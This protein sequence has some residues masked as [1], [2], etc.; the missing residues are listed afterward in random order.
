MDETVESTLTAR[1]REA[2]GDDRRLACW[3]STTGEEIDWD[4]L[5]FRDDVREA[6]GDTDEA[7][8]NA[9]R[10]IDDTSLDRPG[11]SHAERIHAAGDLRCTTRVFEAAVAVHVG[12]GDHGRIVSD[13]QAAE[14][15][16]YGFVTAAHERLERADRDAQP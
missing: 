14:V 11:D 15:D 3:Y 2:F 7:R 9:A 1:C 8:T 10:V 16:Q 13:D 12:A 5:D 6:C 4:V